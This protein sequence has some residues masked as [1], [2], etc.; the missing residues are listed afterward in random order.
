MKG[1]I[2]GFCRRDG[3]GGDSTGG[4][5]SPARPPIAS[6]LLS[7][8]ESYYLNGSEM[9]VL[10]PLSAPQPLPD[11]NTDCFPWLAVCLRARGAV[12]GRGCQA[13]QMS[14]RQ[15]TD[16]QHSFCGLSCLWD[17]WISPTILGGIPAFL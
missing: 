10:A 11:V 5:P 7:S 14:S 4:H 9:L 6:F 3:V 12:L 16:V 15:D 8:S 13:S 1:D 2:I 17:P